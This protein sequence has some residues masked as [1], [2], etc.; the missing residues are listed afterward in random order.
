MIRLTYIACVLLGW[1]IPVI[2]VTPAGIK[3]ESGFI[4]KDKAMKEYYSDHWADFIQ[5]IKAGE[6]K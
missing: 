6:T 1:G 3:L 4:T 2:Q 5:T